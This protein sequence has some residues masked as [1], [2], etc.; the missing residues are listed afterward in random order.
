[1]IPQITVGVGPVNVSEVT[2]VP[3]PSYDYKYTVERLTGTVSNLAELQQAILFILMTERYIYPIYSRNY[4]VNFQ[5][6]V[7]KDFSYIEA[8]IGNTIK[9]AL[10]QDD[11]IN[12]VEIISIAKTGIDQCLIQMIV[13][14]T[15]GVAETEVILDLPV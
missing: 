12:D 11:R 1:M 8:T 9:E 3:Y 15:L 10:T 2:V 14:S 13:N 4:G 5:Q 7:G 6:Y